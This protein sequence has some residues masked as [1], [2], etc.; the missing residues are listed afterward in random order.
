MSDI[1][2]A[3]PLDPN[4]SKQLQ[5]PET[6]KS[7]TPLSASEGSEA[8]LGFTFNSHAA[9]IE[10]KSKFLARMANEMVKQIQANNERMI[11]ALK[12]LRENQ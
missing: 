5:L 10:F 8:Y 4:K 3:G 7:Q 6:K 11:R 2:P 1:K 9:M 12:K